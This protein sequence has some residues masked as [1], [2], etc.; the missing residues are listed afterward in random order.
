[1]RR[2]ITDHGLSFIFACKEEPRPWLAETLN[3][4][5]LEAKE[6][7]GSHYII[8]RYRWYNGVPIR[9]SPQTLLVNYACLE[10]ESGKSGAITYRNSWITGKAVNEE[11]VARTAS[12]GRA[13]WKIGNGHNNALKNRGYNLEHNFGHGQERASEMF[14]LLNLLSFLFHG[15]LSFTDGLYEKS[16][17]SAGRRAE[18]FGCFRLGLRAAL[19]GNWGALLNFV[20]AEDDEEPG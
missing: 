15:I 7:K 9:D 3:N 5:Y 17:A 10:T 2:Q 1:M 6:W 13:R 8:S 19:H 12:C 18:F 11:N 16:R 20:L 4:P 14:C